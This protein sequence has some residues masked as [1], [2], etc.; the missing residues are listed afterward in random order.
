MS[1]MPLL[2]P[3]GAL[4][5]ALLAAT[6]AV[7][8]EGGLTIADTLRLQ[9][10]EAVQLSPDGQRVAYTVTVPRG[11][12]EEAGPAYSQLHVAEIAS[13]R[14]LPFITGAVNVRD[15]RWSPNGRTIA[16]L[17]KRGE[18]AHVQVWAIPVDG[19]EARRLTNAAG[20]VQAF[21]FHPDGTRLLFSAQQPQ[22]KRTTELQK[23]GYGFIVFEEN[24]RPTDL[25]AQPLDGGE[26]V[27]LT[28]DLTVWGLEPTPDGSGVV[29]A[30]S[31]KNLVDH[32]YMFQQLYHLNL[33][34]KEVR[35]LTRHAGKLGSF[36]VSPDGRH[37]AYVGALDRHDHAASQ[38]WVIPLAGGEARNLTPA[39]FPGHV[40]GLLWRDATTLLVHTA[41]GVW[42]HL[43]LAPLAGGPWTVLL[44]GRAA[45]VVVGLPSASRDGAVLAFAGSSASVPGDVYVWQVRGLGAPRRLTERNPWLAE[46]RLGRQEL[47]RYRARDGLDIEGILVYPLDYE[48]GKRYPLIVSVHGGPEAHFSNGWLTRYLDPAQ[49]LAAKGYLAFYPN[50]RGSTG[51][52]VEFARSSF[53]D[54]AGAEFDD[55]ADGIAHLVT[56]GLADGDRVGV[57][58]GS[59]GGYAA[60]WFASYYTKLVRA[61]AMFVGISDLVSKVGTTDIPWED[62]LVHIGRPLEEVWDLMRERSPIF[63]ARQSRSAVLILHGEAD[64]RVHPS[65][66]LAMYRRLKMHDHPATRLVFYPGEGHGNARQTSRLDVLCRHLA[67]YDHYV[68]DARPLD[69]PLPPADVSDCYGLSLSLE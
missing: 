15:A 47:V 30:A 67:W 18:D 27:Q 14:H 53:G 39:G 33:S 25:Y 46:R 2:R 24:E 51:Y 52:G 49:V 9:S 32:R 3:I 23:K 68:R 26:A 1:Q 4:C 13:G 36:A 37:V 57:G 66:S 20:D 59:Y 19:G 28:R 55:V 7:A 41:E 43:R 21:H 56:I 6:A 29:F 34:S 8:A 31:Q 64:T 61:V 65:Q 54:P 42:N 44:D 12:D 11:V 40:L 62:Q 63:W 50:Y 48:K 22:A 17:A 10:C 35:Q 45:G 58:G 38:A 5:V 16:F 69:G 60:A